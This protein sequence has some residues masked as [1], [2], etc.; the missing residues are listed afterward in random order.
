MKK[1]AVC[2]ESEIQDS[3]IEVIHRVPTKDKAKQNIVVRFASRKVRDRVLKAA[4][5]HRLNTSSLG[6]KDNL[7]IFI[8]EHL[9]S[10]NKV[11]LSKALNAKR[12][13]KWKFT[14]VSDGK[15]LMCKTENS[16]VAHVTCAEDLAQ[17]Q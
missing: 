7:P 4:K 9:C 5:K 14:W 1:I 16:R 6:L 3:D 11:L 15:I 8:N 17:V 10:A 2:V 13:H 12:E